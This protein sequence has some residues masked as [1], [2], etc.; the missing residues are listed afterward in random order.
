MK[1]RAFWR[2]YSKDKMLIESINP[3]FMVL[4]LWSLEK[5]QPTKFIYNRETGHREVRYNLEI[6]YE[7]EVLGTV[8]G[9]NGKLYI[10]QKPI[11]AT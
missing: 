3:E 2:K 7:E 4:N 11:L 9:I 5:K 10:L 6:N 1:K 8:K